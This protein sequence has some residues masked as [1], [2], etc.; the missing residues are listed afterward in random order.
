MAFAL[1]LDI[2]NVLNF[3]KPISYA[4]EDIPIFGQVWARQLPRQ[5]RLGKKRDRLLF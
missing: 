5:A 4:K 2:F 3:Q 1:R